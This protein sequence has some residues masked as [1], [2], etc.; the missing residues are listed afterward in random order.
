[1]NPRY[2]F[3]RAPAFTRYLDR[4]YLAQK[5]YLLKY[6]HVLTQIPAPLRNLHLSPAQKFQSLI[7]LT[8]VVMYKALD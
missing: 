5:S 7:V 3:N 4:Y 6:D 2:S 1:M 8:A